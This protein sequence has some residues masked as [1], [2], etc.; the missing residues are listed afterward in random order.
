MVYYER[1]GF[2]RLNIT[3]PLIFFFYGLAFFTMG[4]VIVLEVGRCADSRLRHALR[5]LCVFGFL[6]GTHE[7]V[8]MFETIGPLPFQ[9]EYPLLWESVRILFLAISFLPLAEF[10][11]SL[12]ISDE[13]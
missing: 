1:E 10:G 8:E 7:W 3:I 6:H 13:K 5:F 4:S 12:L 2:A 9:R 11:A